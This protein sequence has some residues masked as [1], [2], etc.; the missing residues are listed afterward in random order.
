MLFP[1]P[2]GPSIA[3]IIVYLRPHR[4]ASE[5]RISKNPGSLPSTHSAPSISRPSRE[6]S[7]ASAPIIAIRWSPT[8]STTP[9]PLGRLGTPRTRNPS[10][11]G[12]IREPSALMAFVTASIRSVLLR[13]QLLRAPDDALTASDRRAEGEERELVDEER[14]LGGPISVAVSS[15]EQTSR[16]ATGS[17]PAFRRL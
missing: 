3:T 2:A 5:S 9:P 8:D 12:V 7:P 17:P 16:S 15:A 4:T 1:A 13:P 6:E 14:H 10:G 11:V